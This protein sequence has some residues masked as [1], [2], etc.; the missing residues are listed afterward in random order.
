MF[1]DGRG[2]NEGRERRAGEGTEIIETVHL[3]L[4]AKSG[5]RQTSSL[6]RG[7]A[8]INKR[9]IRSCLEIADGQKLSDEREQNSLSSLGKRGDL[10]AKGP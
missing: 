7:K 8:A 2:A 10:G 6:Y 5:P 1:E 4:T 3:S 9:G